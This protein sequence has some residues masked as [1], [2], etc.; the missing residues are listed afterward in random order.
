MIF[1]FFIA[2][3]L[4]VDL[5][6]WI[7]SDYHIV[8]IIYYLLFGNPEDK[9]IVL[10]KFGL[11]LSENKYKQLK[12]QDFRKNC[13]GAMYHFFDH[14]EDLQNDEEDFLCKILD[15]LG[16]AGCGDLGNT[17]KSLGICREYFG[18]AGEVLERRYNYIEEK[19]NKKWRY[20]DLRKKSDAKKYLQDM[21]KLYSKPF[22]ED[23]LDYGY[24]MDKNPFDN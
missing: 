12:E 11:D 19:P 16:D 3:F 21:W 22:P 24:D 6:C 13:L 9:N 4:I 18:F 5:C 7:F 1:L 2:L 10:N 8:S 15:F 14:K 17:H 20:G 23:W